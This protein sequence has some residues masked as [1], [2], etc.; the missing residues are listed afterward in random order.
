M[1]YD[2][3]IIGA[4]IAGLYFANKLIEN[5][6]KSS[7]I[8]LEKS[9]R[10]GGRIYVRKFHGLN[11]PLG[12]GIG[13][14][15]DKYLK[16]L[17]TDLGINYQVFQSKVSYFKN[18]INFSKNK[19][20]VNILQKNYI[21]SIHK[22]LDFKTYATNILGSKIYQNFIQ[23]QGYY[24]FEN[25]NTHYV[26]NHYGLRHNFGNDSIFYIPWQ[27]LLTKLAEKNNIQQNIKLKSHVVNIINDNNIYR[28]VLLKNGT[29]YTGKN[30]VCATNILFLQS[31][32]KN[33]Y[34]NI[35]GQSF[36]RI[37]IKTDKK[38]PISN[39]FIT[40]N[41]LQKII[42]MGKNNIYMIAY[43]DNTNAQYFHSLSKQNIIKEIKYSIKNLFNI[44]VNIQ[45]I[46]W[47]YWDIGTHYY[48]EYMSKNKIEKY[49]QHPKDNIYVIGE[50]VS[51]K[52]HGWTEG[53]LE[54][55]ENIYKLLNKL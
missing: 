53:A 52:N 36:M 44:E 54:S 12:A 43:I 5:N 19:D 17:L 7:F 22:N 18:D 46:T 8:I 28:K 25:T 1:N 21:H 47:K 27:V 45:S 11:L 41:K 10:I 51:Y 30:I 33:I 37:Y 24:D 20:I 14:N 6:P 13:R 31:I 9:N 50:V 29:V 4:G 49:L 48:K 16:Q 55:V 40:F 3:I 2:Y 35:F 15:K 38:L 34:Q 26:L 39:I 42:P 32:F 23:A